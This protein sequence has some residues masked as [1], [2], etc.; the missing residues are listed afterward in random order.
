MYAKIKLTFMKNAGFTLTEMIIVVITLG[1]VAGFALPSYTKA[2]QKARER[3]A[4]T[5]LAVIHAANTL[6]RSRVGTYYVNPSGTV[7]DINT[8]LGISIIPGDNTYTYSSN[9][10]TTFTASATDGN[11]TIEADE[12]ALINGTNPCCSGGSCRATNDC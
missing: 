11:Y 7:N 8:N 6:Y 3:D 12:G 1:V 2:L 10:G 9:D 4:I 5:Q